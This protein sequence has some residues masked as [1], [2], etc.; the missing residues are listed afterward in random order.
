MKSIGILSGLEMT[1]KSL[2]Y[3]HYLRG[4]TVMSD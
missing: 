1:I 2:K 3:V 4:S